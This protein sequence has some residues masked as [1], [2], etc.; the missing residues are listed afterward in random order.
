VELNTIK[1]TIKHLLVII[2][3]KVRLSQKDENSILFLFRIVIPENANVFYAMNNTESDLKFI[4]R[5][6]ASH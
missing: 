3:V 4:A 1:Q 6:V 2:Y 5:P